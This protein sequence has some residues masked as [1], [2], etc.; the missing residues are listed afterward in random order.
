MTA[1]IKN[2]IL[3]PRNIGWKNDNR[4][5]R[6][7]I[8][9]HYAAAAGFSVLGIMVLD[10]LKPLYTD[11]SAPLVLLSL[12]VVAAAWW[13][14]RGPGLFATLLCV[15]GAWGWLIP[16]VWFGIPHP[17]E[18]LRIV[19]TAFTGVIISVLSGSLSK[20]AEALRQS[21]QRMHA[22]FNHAAMGIIEM[23]QADRIVSANKHILEL[24]GYQL[25]EL[26]G[27]SIHDLTAPEDRVL[28]DELN[29]KIREGTLAIGNFD[30]RYL[31]KNG[32]YI[33]VHVTVS[34][35]RDRYGRFCGSVRT[36]EDI[37]ARKKVEE[38]L[39]R[40]NRDLEHF[41]HMISHDLQEPVR[42]VQS[43]GDLLERH[44]A[45]TLDG[46]ALEY[47]HYMTDGAKRMADLIS[48]LLAYSRVDSGQVAWVRTDMREVAEGVLANLR[49][50]T[51]FAQATIDLGK[52]PIVM[53]SPAQLAQ[54]VQNLIGNALK[55]RKPEVHPVISI[56]AD[57]QGK[58][59]MF[60][61]SDNGIGIDP[62][63]H[64][65]IFELF[66]RLHTTDEYPGI[67]IGLATCKRIVERQGGRIWVE[68]TP[69]QGSTFC[70][71]LPAVPS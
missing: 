32:T 42:M 35:I 23:N 60:S 47:L 5:D 1:F 44:Y 52:M 69:G 64:E 19:L 12:P 28:S 63:Y 49:I 4:G 20:A 67:G 70:F 30:K 45:S 17:G 7:S 71:T 26:L 55:Y 61:I 6:L 3:G 48:G 65:R 14:G 68:S 46:K 66:Q 31:K 8:V 50:A 57:R 16:P 13:G 38:E 24:S 21:E 18:I 34:P 29:A 51:Q 15:L 37:T 27:S 62:A 41:A 22:I 2:N 43:F 36:I 25:D 56:C 53:G 9:Y 10:M 33:W 11:R 39:T 59:W 54:L 40:S 58:D